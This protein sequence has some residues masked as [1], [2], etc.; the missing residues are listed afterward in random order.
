[1]WQ[2]CKIKF[3]NAKLSK[4]MFFAYALL[5]GIML[6]MAIFVF[7]YSFCI[8]NKELYEKSL[9]ELEFFSQR[10][11]KE[12]E[13]IESLSYTLAMDAQVQAALADASNKRYLSLEYYYALRPVRKA[14]L[15]GVNSRQVVYNAKYLNKDTVCISVGK[16]EGEIA[17]ETYSLFMDQCS[18]ARGGYV[19]L[20]PSE[21]YEYLIS[22]RDILEV[23]N[24]S[25]RYLGTVLLT[26]DI[27]GIIEEEKKNLQF[28]ESLL[29]VY[30]GDNVIYKSVQDIPQLPDITEGQGYQI[31]RYCGKHYFMG[32]LQN[33]KTQWTYVNGVPYDTLLRQTKNA[34]SLVGIVLISVWVFAFFFMNILAKIITT[35]LRTLTDTIHIAGLGEFKKA[36]ESLQVEK[37]AEDEIGILTKD[38]GIMLEEIQTLIHENYDKQ[39]LLQETKYKMLQ[40]QINP[41]FLYNTLNALNWMVKAGK[42]N[43][44]G[45]MIIE[46]GNLMRASFSKEAYVSA[47]TEIDI[48][49]SY[50]TIQQ[51]RYKSRVVFDIKTEGNLSEYQVPK[52]ILQPLVENAIHYGVDQ[53]L[54]YSRICVEAQEIKEEHCLI[55]SVSDEGVGMTEE[56]I[57]AVYNGTIIPKGN[58]I[59][60]KNIIERLK[61]TYDNSS[62]QIESRIHQGTKIIMKIPKEHKI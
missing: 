46:L 19:S 17:D 4:K 37:A 27:S 28:S 54:E 18:N 61:L 16:E 9:Q 35:P 41:H 58:G 51:F 48:V 29:F 2:K 15:N 1:M 56:E 47:E 60:L 13:D 44:A 20:P 40:A 7:Q 39:L 22:G 32:Y 42:N 26:S 31:I 12:L 59:G 25:L 43:E 8:T 53:S 30:E 57:Q 36:Q 45:K 38:F 49:R 11:D 34:R 55:L 10:V 3:A 50:I 52:M 23:E 6:I 5:A 24:A 33:S 62:F 14:F 21:N